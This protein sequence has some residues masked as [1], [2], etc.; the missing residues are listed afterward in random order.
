VRPYRQ[1]AGR[2]KFIP[3]FDKLNFFLYLN[4]Y[5]QVWL[6]RPVAIVF[7]CA[8]RNMHA[9]DVRVRSVPSSSH[10]GYPPVTESVVLPPDQRMVA[11]SQLEQI[12][13]PKCQSEMS[14]GLITPGP[15]GYS[16]RT[17]ECDHCA[18]Q[19]KTAAKLGDPMRSKKTTNWFRGELVAPK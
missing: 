15:L 16:L 11:M 7:K 19:I 1:G 12:P 9:S 5:A 8:I 2:I 14:L 10:D 6:G 3:E 17:F 13:C 18:H 4:D